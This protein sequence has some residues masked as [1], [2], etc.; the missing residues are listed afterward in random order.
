MN[1]YEQLGIWLKGYTPVKDWIYF[2]SIQMEPD[3]FSL[4][5]VTGST[6]VN[7]FLDGSTERDLV[8]AIAMVS[9]YDNEMSSTNLDAI[10][11]IDTFKSWMVKDGGLPDF[12]ENTIVNE[13]VIIDD[14][15]DVL[16]DSDQRVC[17][18]KFQAKVNYLQREE[19]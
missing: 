9:H 11:E 15:P 7:K 18:Y 19:I 13:I 16:V 12:G 4:N 1:L 3:N 14:V 2:N 6:V 10:E 17:Q 8:F 5:T